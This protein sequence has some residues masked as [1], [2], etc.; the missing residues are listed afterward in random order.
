MHLPT[1]REK[2]VT[3]RFSVRGGDCSGL[4]LLLG[5]AKL[6]HSQEHRVGGCDIL[7]TPQLP[8]LG[9]FTVRQGMEKQ[10]SHC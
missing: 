10:G 5:K 9:F 7:V 2:A 8:S 6:R 3:G 4:K 1:S